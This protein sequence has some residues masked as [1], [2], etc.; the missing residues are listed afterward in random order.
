MLGGYSDMAAWKLER[1]EA[2]RPEFPS[3]LAFRLSSFLAFRGLPSRLPA[4]KHPSLPLGRNR[5]PRIVVN[6]AE[7]FP[8]DG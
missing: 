8:D 3:L 2:G 1:D 4:F 7:I 6:Q 5:K